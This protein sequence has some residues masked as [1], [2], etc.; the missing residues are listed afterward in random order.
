[1]SILA[2]SDFNIGRFIIP[3]NPD[4]TNDVQAY[5]DRIEAYYLPRLFGKVLFD[6]FETDYA[7]SGTGPTDPR[8]IAVFEAFTTQTTQSDFQQSLGMIDML[9]GFVYFEYVRDNVTRLTTTGI[10]RTDSANSENVS[11]IHHDIN[12]RYNESIATYLAVQYF[13]SQTNEVDYP[14]YEGIILKFNHTF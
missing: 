5:I 10:K 12:S 3:K 11:A 4:Q 6:L 14:E 1:M 7:I 13:M 2:P 9:K 8:F